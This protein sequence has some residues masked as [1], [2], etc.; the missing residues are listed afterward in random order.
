MYYTYENDKLVAKGDQYE[1]PSS[2]TQYGTGETG[3]NKGQAN[4]WEQGVS[5]AGS[6]VLDGMGLGMFGQLGKMGY[7]GFK[8]MDNPAGDVMSQFFGPHHVM[9]GNVDDYKAGMIDKKDLGKVQA[10]NTLGWLLPGIGSIW[11]AIDQGKRRRDFANNAKYVNS[12]NPFLFALD[13]KGLQFSNPKAKAPAPVGDKTGWI[14]ALSSMV[15]SGIKQ[16]MPANKKNEVAP[17]TEVDLNQD[18]PKNLAFMQN[19]L[20]DNIAVDNSYKSSATRFGGDSPISGYEDQF[21]WSNKTQGFNE[22][23]S[24]KLKKEEVLRAVQQAEEANRSKKYEPTQAVKNTKATL[25]SASLLTPT[26]LP[27][28]IGST[29]FDLGT[30]TKYA[31][32]G[33]YDKATEDAVQ[34]VL[35]WIPFLQQ[36]NMINL[37]KNTV[38]LAYR[39]NQAIPYINQV[40]T[41]T[42]KAND[43]KTISE[44]Y[45]KDKPNIL[46]G[47]MFSTSIPVDNLRVE[48][49]K[50]KIAFQ[51][52][53]S[54]IV[55]GGKGGDDIALV[56]TNTGE[57]TGVRVEKDEMIVFSKKNVEALEKAIA[58]G[59]KSAVFNIVKDQLSQHPEVKEGET[60]FKG[61]GYKDL[62]DDKLKSEYESAKKKPI[63]KLSL[64]E[65]KGYEKEL[66]KRGL[67]FK[68]YNLL[69]PDGESPA[70]DLVMAPYNLAKKVLVDLPMY[71]SE[72]ANDYGDPIKDPKG[73][74]KI[75]QTKVDQ[76]YEKKYGKMGVDLGGLKPTYDRKKWKELEA[77]IRAQDLD[78]A[79]KGENVNKVM[80]SDNEK[81]TY[82]DRNVKDVFNMLLPNAEKTVEEEAKK[83]G[84]DGI[85]I[86]R[87]DVNKKSNGQ[88]G[89]SQPN[90]RTST[91]STTTTT[92]SG[93]QSSK[94][95]N[96]NIDDKSI[97]MKGVA[98]P[99][100]GMLN[101][102]DIAGK[103]Q[104]P[105]AKT[106]DTEP[107]T[108]KQD[109][110]GDTLGYAG[111]ALKL[112]LG[113]SAATKKL[114]EWTISDNWNEYMGKMKFM[115]NMG[116]SPEQ[117][118][119]Y[120]DT[121]DRTYQYDL[122]NIYNLSNG[123]AG[124]VLGNIGRA[125]MSR[126]RSG[127]DLAIADKNAELANNAV[128]GNW[129]GRDEQ[130]RKSI[131]DENR[132]GLLMTKQAGMQLAS[133][134]I[135]NMENR[136][137][138]NKFYGKGSQVEKLQNLQLEEQQ[139]KN[140]ILKA[141]RDNAKNPEFWKTYNPWKTT[142]AEHQ[143]ATTNSINKDDATEQSGPKWN[144]KITDK[145]LS[146]ERSFGA[147]GGNPF[148]SG[149]NNSDWSN[150]RFEKEYVDKV[151]SE[152][153]NFDSLPDKIK[154]RLVD[155]KFNTGR[156]IG[157][158]I[159]VA[160]G[161]YTATDANN[162]KTLGNLTEEQ[163]ASLNSEDFGK[164][165]DNAKLE[166]YKM[167]KQNDVNY[168]KNLNMNWIPRTNMWD[169][170]EF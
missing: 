140:D 115:S 16:G 9:L 100:P 156:S 169:N 165:I 68:A 136:A 19:P 138:Y 25:A 168:K 121:A 47:D 147:P 125:N 132:N 110:L 96:V 99:D 5:N 120:L 73:Y 102:A 105:Y 162:K 28:R 15:G 20:G 113:M 75:L 160:S 21:N 141:Q 32:D 161:K 90:T 167:T 78:K 56:D 60:M 92:T 41:Y 51:G 49:Q 81:P 72:K 71:L 43:V 53:G 33:Q 8:Q 50:R 145:I 124:T 135:A 123:N 66:E 157:D 118:A 22:G 3:A 58:S 116:L 119:Q 64:D 84:K 153:P 62:S 27:A 95:D 101:V 117:K 61:G 85:P 79:K 36:K 93:Q 7:N 94:T 166:I 65:L 144:S 87:T 24:V 42:N 89:W 114:P 131:F 14:A 108:V 23:G 170:F 137:D 91:S 164:K 98:Q 54:V 126:Y 129:L 34:A 109:W 97:A 31:L 155:Y 143:V 46:K 63:G 77:D 107:E 67:E 148:F 163:I 52:G 74:E 30:A 152:I 112:G 29:I 80:P 57:D 130:Y 127:V 128:Y 35:N 39:F 111:D 86:I 83:I 44:V 2:Y 17:N 4:G 122:S 149:Y 6:G 133:D 38:P 59:K 154:A 55:E 45:S 70:S 48:P 10:Q 12:T 26:N 11:G 37:S 18:Q 103:L 13:D 158:L 142:S 88:S 146:H 139:T 106:V 69:G 104:T 151:R 1:N 40:N 134:A 82:K 76:L 150:G 159:H